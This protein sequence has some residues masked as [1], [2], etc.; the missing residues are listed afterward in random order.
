MDIEHLGHA[1]LRVTHDGTSLLL[2]PGVFSPGLDAHLGDTDGLLAVLVT[3]AHPDHLDPELVPLLEH[4]GGPGAI[5]AEAGAADVVEQAGGTPA[6]LQVGDRRQWGGIH[7]DVVGG[8]HAEIHPDIPRIGNVGL[9]LRAGGTSL[10]HPGDS[11]DAVPDD[12]DVLALPLNAPW[13]KVSETVEFVRAVAP[14]VV[15]PVHDALLQPQRREVYLAHVRNLGGAAV[16]DPA[17]D[18][19]L[20]T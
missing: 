14:R 10:F 15:V 7:L 16:H 13:A 12:V 6:V 18:G 17:H 2:D 9:V 3:H 5:H 8:R 19:V 20:T 4:H 1:C 11:Y